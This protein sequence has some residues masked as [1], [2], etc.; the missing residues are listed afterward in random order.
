MIEK[1]SIV[2]LSSYSSKVYVPVVL[3]DSKVAFI[4]KRK[5]SSFICLLG[6]VYM[7]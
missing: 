6:C 2:N 3:S 4:G 5:N 1:R 7:L